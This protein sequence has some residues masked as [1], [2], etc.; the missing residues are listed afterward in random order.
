M[1]NYRDAWKYN[2]LRRVAE[3]VASDLERAIE[4]G[5]MVRAP[6]HANRVYLV[7]AKLQGFVGAHVESFRS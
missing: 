4:R 5:D 2:R 6:R 3:R 7:D 1:I